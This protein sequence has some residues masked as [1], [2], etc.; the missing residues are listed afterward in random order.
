M[1]R[2]QINGLIREGEAFFAG[3]GLALPAWASWEP[4]QW[5]GSRATASEIATAS[6]GW[7]ITDFG[8]GDYSRRGLFLFTLRNG[9]L[10]SGGKTYAEKAMIVKVDQETPTHFHDHKMEDII[11]RGGGDLCIQLWNSDQ[12]DGLASTPVEVRIDGILR[13]LP[14]ASTVRLGPGE[15]ICLERRLYHRFW[16]EKATVLVGEVS[17][18]ND[19]L[20]D[21][22]FLEGVGRFPAIEEDEA[23]YRLLV[24]DYPAWITD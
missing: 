7:D 8:S 23:P 19:D 14:A 13:R 1:K 22:H 10:G 6:L 17:M 15:S 3:R 11:N 9:V 2:S 5:R 18:V 21:N 20:R 16:G 12:A 24:S 4:R